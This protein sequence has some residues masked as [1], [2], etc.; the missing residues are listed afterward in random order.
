MSQAS[1]KSQE[2]T[3]AVLVIGDEILSGRTQD[4]N[5]NYI[6]KFLG[7]L[8]IDLKEARVVPDVQDEI[9]A[10]LNVLRTRYTYVFTTGGIGP[11]H[12]DI[13]ADAVATAFDVGID[14][15]PEA[16]TLM[17]ARYK[18]PE[19]FNEMRKRMARIPFT[20]RLV[21]NS[22]STAPGFQI[23]NVFVMAGVPAIMRAMMEE[24]APRLSR[25]SVV[26][27]A[28]V[29]AKVPEGRIAKGLQDIQ[30]RHKNVALGS[31]PFYREDG[32]GVQLVAR[33]RDASE[34]EVA[35]KEI[36]SLIE[37]EGVDPIR[38][39]SESLPEQGVH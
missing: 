4:T 12:D 10:A 7:E 2:I 38:I 14:Y 17:A 30:A 19:D 1:A 18:N 23:G 11:T 28:T 20:A 6:A 32:A 35:A 26:H 25:G 21:K 15:H 5:T 33:G 31:Y 22:V 37:S 8:G 34:V 36:E 39:Q 13:T 27:T 9:V 29:E 24:I 16:L 3:A